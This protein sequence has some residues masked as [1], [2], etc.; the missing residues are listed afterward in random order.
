MGYAFPRNRQW[1][2]QTLFEGPKDISKIKWKVSFKDTLSISSPVIDECSNIIF[3]T[4]KGE[5]ISINKQGDV[6]WHHRID[7]GVCSSPVICQDG[8]IYIG[9]S[10]DNMST[11]FKLDPEGKKLW[12]IPLKEGVSFE[13]VFDQ[14]GDIFIATTDSISKVNSLGQLIWSH[15]CGN[16]SSCPIVDTAGNVYISSRN[17]SGIISL[18]SDGEM[19][20]K[21]E[22]GK[23]YLEN[24]P[25]IDSSGNMYFLVSNN[26]EHSLYSIDSEGNTNWKFTPGN[27]GII[28]NLALSRDNYL[29]MGTTYFKVIAIN[30]SGE[31]L[32]ERD[33]GQITQFSPV[34]DS[35]N[36]IY[37]YTHFHKRKIY[38]NI[39]KLDCEGQ[40]I[41]NHEIKDSVEWFHF[42]DNNELIFLTIDPD[43]YLLSL[44]TYT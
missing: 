22:L 44:I 23:C 32:W 18:S 35:K 41:W 25:I 1:S 9:S 15:P 42:N 7:T 21:K 8:F 14:S 12:S 34:L 6:N 37:L 40:I 36:N 27:R 24:E 33:L 16:V 28:S 4:N 17:E 3:G 43:T 29:V 13:P 30:L 38:S 20:W 10:G 5:L 39:W 2:R 26:N 11:L 31:L 19:R